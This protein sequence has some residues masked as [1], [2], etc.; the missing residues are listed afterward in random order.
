[1]TVRRV[2]REASKRL[3]MRVCNR[4]GRVLTLERPTRHAHAIVAKQLRNAV[5]HEPHKLPRVERIRSR[6]VELEE[7]GDG[8]GGLCC[9]AGRRVEH[10]DDEVA[11]LDADHG[12]WCGYLIAELMDAGA[13]P[14]VAS[15]KLLEPRLE[16]RVAGWGLAQAG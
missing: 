4:V 8:I 13:Q 15:D 2:S 16:G 11:V 3:Y 12:V 5:S 6:G 9:G 14:Y 10:V 7:L 1:M